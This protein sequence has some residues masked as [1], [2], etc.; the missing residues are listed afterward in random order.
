MKRKYPFGQCGLCGVILTSKNKVVHKENG[1]S[2]ICKECNKQRANDYRLLIVGKWFW[3]YPYEDNCRVCGVPLNEENWGKSNQKNN[4]KICKVCACNNS[5]EWQKNNREIS[6]KYK[7]EWLKERPGYRTKVSDKYSRSPR[8]RIS[9]HKKHSKRK[10]LGFNPLNEPFKNSNG[11]H[12][13]LNDVIYIP[14]NIHESISHNVFKG[15]NMEKINTQA[16][17]FLLQQNIKEFSLL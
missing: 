10:N 13:N 1:K 17:F 4:Y 12:I 2:Y 15:R 5:I 9:A 7:K 11:H 3:D 16:Y 14:E 8:G 6:N